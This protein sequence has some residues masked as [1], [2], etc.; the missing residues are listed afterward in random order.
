MSYDIYKEFD[1]YNS[2]SD[3][4]NS[5]TKDSQGKGKIAYESIQDLSGLESESTLYFNDLDKLFP[6]SSIRINGNKSYI[7]GM[8]AEDDPFGDIGQDNADFGGTEDSGGDP[9]DA[10][11][12]FGS[13]DGGDP[14]ADVGTDSGGGDP[15]GGD[16]GDPFGDVGGGD[17]DDPFGGMGDDSGQ[18]QQNQASRQIKLD[19][20][21]T[22]KED[23]NLSR[24]IR[25]NFPKKFLM[26]KD[27]ITNNITIL[28]RTVV[29]DERFDTIVAKMVA[30][31]EKIYDLINTYLDIIP[32]KTYEDIFG[33]YVS[34]HSAMMRL[35][36]SYLQ[37]TNYDDPNAMDNL[38]DHNYDTDEIDS[39]VN[40]DNTSI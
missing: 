6:I 19:R 21:K 7:I 13:G 27:I 15:F 34:I 30:E 10:G 12:A 18:N 29:T 2:H 9:F 38:E 16:G 35:K 25:Q 31:Y 4:P 32:R 33:T 11:D 1:N 17:S 36:K 8:E 23:Y 5:F 3:S 40:P 26:M 37:L 20:E 24:Q 28:E 14:F 22:I 39:D